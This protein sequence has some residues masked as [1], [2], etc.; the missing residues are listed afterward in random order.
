[1]R[2]VNLRTLI[3]GAA[4]IA[5][6]ACGDDVTVVQPVPTLTLNPAS[7]SCTQGQVTAVGVTVGGATTT[8][9]VTF[10][11]SGTAATVAPSGT[12]GAT[13]TC[14][15]VGSAVIT[16]SAV[17]NGQTVTGS[18]P[19]TVTAAPSQI[20]AVSV[21]PNQATIVVGGTVTL[22]PTVI[23]SVAGANTA[24]TYTSLQ[25][26]IATVDANGVVRG[27]AAGTATIR[28]A[29]VASPNIV[30]TA[31]ISVVPTSAFV[32][33][34]SV[35]PS[36]ISLQ[37]GATQSL[38]A[39]VTLA[40]GAPA[41]TS[42]GVT[43][44]SSDT[45]V[46]RV[47]TTGVITAV[48][49]G[50]AV[51]T[52]A[53]VA[54]PNVTQTVSVT[55]RDPAPVRLTIQS[56]NVNT[57][58]G[59]QPADLNNI[60]GNI[61]VNL[62]LDPGDFRP[63]S[64]LVKLGTQTVNC[65]RFSAAFVEALRASLT[66]GAA[67]V[68]QI[69]CQ[70]N[71]SQ[72]APTTGVAS[73]I[74][75]RQ[76]LTAQVFFRPQGAASGSQSQ[77]ASVPLELTV[78]NQSGFFVNVTNT[79]TDAQKTLSG[80]Q[81]GQ[82]TG[83]QGV[84]WRAGAI[85]VT[86]L[87]VN[88][89]NVV[90]PGTQTFTVTL[91]DVNGTVAQRTAGQDAGG[92]ATYSVS[93]PGTSADTP[94][95]NN[96]VTGYT[97]PNAGQQVITGGGALNSGTFVVVGTAAATGNLTVLNA[98]GQPAGLV[99]GAFAFPN[100]LAQPIYIDNQNPE[101]RVQFVSNN[102]IVGAGGNTGFI[103]GS[104]VFADSVNQAA[105]A[106]TLAD[107]NGVDRVSRQFFFATN[108]AGITPADIIANG[109]AVTNG[110]QIPQ[111]PSATAFAA[112]ARLADALGN[113]KSVQVSALNG[114]PLYS[115][116]VITATPTISITNASTVGSNGQVGASFAGPATITF[117]ATSTS[118]VSF[119]AA[120]VVGTL[121]V[122]RPNGQVYC[123]IAADVNGANQLTGVSGTTQTPPCPQ[124][125]FNTVN[126]DPN[127]ALSGVYTL[128]VQSRDVAGNLSN[129]TT[130]TF[131]IDRTGPTVIN[132]ITTTAPLTGGTS[133]TFQATASDDFALVAQTVLEDFTTATE[134]VLRYDGSSLGSAFAQPFT[135]NASLSV[136]VPNF[137]R[138]IALQSSTVP[139]TGLNSNAHASPNGIAVGASDPGANWAYSVIG[140]AA[141][142]SILDQAQTAPTFFGAADGP[143]TSELRFQASTA[144][145]A[146][147]GGFAATLASAT[148]GTPTNE[149]INLVQVG[150]ANTPFTNRFARVQLFLRSNI[151]GT[152]P[153][154]GTT[155][156]RLIGDCS[157][158]AISISTTSSTITNSCPVVPGSAG[159]PA[160]PTSGTRAV[161]LL[162]LATDANGYAAAYIIPTI[163]L[164]P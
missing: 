95:G 90:N 74:N 66:T 75:G 42:T 14:A 7:V 128:N 93:F 70:V 78:N 63:D 2:L 122:L 80:N 96:T 56:V 117:S 87:P 71:T 34:L 77:S 132:A 140:S 151:P 149:T 17:A 115:F 123:A 48:R 30:A 104:F 26:N 148:S 18:I 100:T 15:Q 12:N 137:V 45:S 157:A 16:V 57:A 43:Y 141:L 155:A 145:S 84:L 37:T 24:V 59:T 65:Q 81:T 33:S 73:V 105:A 139:A 126:I 3:A 144:T 134:I 97:S 142:A 143:A 41:G 162:V 10:T 36:A 124:L 49:N 146:T 101:A 120:Y 19:V 159:V 22:T 133:E 61:Y 27:V 4:S 118:G 6:V 106:T 44:V 31:T 127:T 25:T 135:K 39:T 13:V 160:F 130:R 114:G 60:A 103:N 20:Q 116:G 113:A 92:A 91:Q 28:V 38:A 152:T 94:A 158:A 82:A 102:F 47:S 107:N 110:S 11:S 29:S 69:T 51:V 83:P 108:V 62:N 52:V 58:T 32:Q 53:S 111:N 88:F 72:F 68:Q 98:A 46:A 23:S 136:T 163:T 76:P 50:T 64:V 161:D 54:A 156:Y 129:A 150:A 21:S 138:S 119:P 99:Q 125:A 86:L 131:V 85:N 9:T 153:F 35:Q 55:V 121:Q 164:N 147:T 112:A 79:P 109:T 8:P 67:D 154:I 1:M 89:T 5:L 40:P